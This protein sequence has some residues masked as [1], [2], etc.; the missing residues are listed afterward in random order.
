MKTLI[1]IVLAV[2]VVVFFYQA[3]GR[4]MLQEW[5]N[6][7]LMTDV[8]VPE[9]PAVNAEFAAIEAEVAEDLRKARGY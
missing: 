1:I 2:L 4:E 9:D 8:K 7:L 5:L 3:Q 6:S